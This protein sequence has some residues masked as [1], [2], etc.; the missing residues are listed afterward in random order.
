MEKVL[1]I[2]LYHLCTYQNLMYNFD[3]F[4]LVQK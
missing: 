3:D 1:T 4:Y 2:F